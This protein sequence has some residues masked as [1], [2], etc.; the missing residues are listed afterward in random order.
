MANIIVVVVVGGGGADLIP[1]LIIYMLGN[2]H[3]SELVGGF[4]HICISTPFCSSLKIFLVKPIF[5]RYFGKSVV[6]TASSEMTKM[7][8]DMSLSIQ[9]LLISRT[10]FS[11]FIIFSASFLG[12]L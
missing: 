2:L 9:T 11:Y 8:I 4:R 1:H 5:C 12:R 6:N 10:K 7:H 3:L